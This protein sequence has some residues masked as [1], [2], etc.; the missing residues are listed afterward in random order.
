MIDLSICYVVGAG[1]CKKLDFIPGNDDL[2]IASDGGLEH[3]EKCGIKPDIII[4][5]FD[6]LCK[7]PQGEN[8]IRLKPEKDI[9]DMDAAVKVGIEKGYEEFKLYGALGGRLDHTL[10]CLGILENVNKAGGFALITDG[11][12][13]ARYLRNT[14]ELIA[15]SDFRYFSLIA[16]DPVVKGVSIEGGKYPLKNA[17]LRREHQFAVSNE[18]DGNCAL[19]TVRRGAVILIESSDKN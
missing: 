1:E 15:R 18:V 7:N 19:V 16:V 14:S 6:S 12:N 11:K 13:R 2:I 3:L 8:V 4:G 17:T 9:T 5:D 10:S